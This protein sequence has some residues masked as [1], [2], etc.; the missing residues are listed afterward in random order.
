MA[1]K[2]VFASMGDAHTYLVPIVEARLDGRFA[3]YDRR[4]QAVEANVAKILA[5]HPALTNVVT[6]MHVPPPP[7]DPAIAII[8]GSGAPQTD[9]VAPAL[10]GNVYVYGDAVDGIEVPT[11]DCPSLDD[12]TDVPEFDGYYW[13]PALHPDATFEVDYERREVKVRLGWAV[14]DNLDELTN[15]PDYYPAPPPVVVAFAVPYI[16]G[17]FHLEANIDGLEEVYLYL[18]LGSN[19]V[20]DLAR[21]FD[22][23]PEGDDDDEAEGERGAPQPLP[24]PEADASKD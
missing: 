22:F 18:P 3:D 8:T 12:Y 5:A 17:D 24:Q 20:R 1:K 14:R 13:Q 7:A 10:R 2:V 23:N 4:L 19:L 16:G 9:P 6:A 21:L 11:L 15:P